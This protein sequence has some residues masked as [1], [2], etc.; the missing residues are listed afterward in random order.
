MATL[1]NRK[2][3]SDWIFFS[4]RDVIK[5][6]SEEEP[7][8]GTIF[9]IDEQQVGAGAKD[10]ASK[11]NKA[12]SAFMSTVRSNRYIIITTLP[13]SDMEDKQL[14]RLFHLEIE[15]FGANPATNTV[16]SKP[17]YLEH[18]RTRDKTY[19]KRM[20]VCF[21]DP[22]TGINKNVKIST[23]DIAKPSEN[24]LTDYER[25]KSEFKRILYKR[26]KRELDEYDSARDGTK[27]LGAVAPAFTEANLTDYQKK[28]FEVFKSG[29]KTGKEANEELLRMGVPSSEAKISANKKWMKNKGVIIL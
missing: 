7:K 12:Y 26:L 15:C 14:R 17:R 19:R 18:S 16:K 3:T 4:I 10:H 23:W 11:R 13:F 29:V 22:N 5:R 28:L 25:M 21:K 6:V 8:P 1:M 9:F 2:F 27:T 20:V 24:L